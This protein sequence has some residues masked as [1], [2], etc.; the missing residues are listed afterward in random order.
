MKLKSE[1]MSNVLSLLLWALVVLSALELLSTI[2]YAIDIDFFIE[3]AYSLNGFVNLSSVVLYYIILVI[4]LIWIYRIHMDL[5]AVFPNYPRS[6]GS[7]LAC[8]MVPFYNFYGIPSTYNWIGTHYSR[9]AIGVEK[10]GRIIRWLA[11]P[12]IIFFFITNVLSKYI[13]RIDDPS[14][15]V[16]LVHSAF[17][18]TLYCIFLTLCIN[19][20]RGLKNIQVNA[21]TAY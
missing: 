5:I 20:S 21:P 4:Y 6:P 3:H 15:T 17:E 9:E 16:L 10:Q 18:F 7:S 12:L 19:V 1:L 14:T 8:M 13:S 11:A 2:I